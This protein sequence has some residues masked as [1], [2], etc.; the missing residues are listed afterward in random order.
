MTS[1]PMQSYTWCSYF[2]REA[3]KEAKTL[4][5]NYSREVL[6][7]NKFSVRRSKIAFSDVP[8]GRQRKDLLPQYLSNALSH[9]ILADAT[10]PLGI[11]IYSMSPTNG[12]N[13]DS[14]GAYQLEWFPCYWNLTFEYSSSFMKNSALNKLRSL[15]SHESSPFTHHSIL[16]SVGWKWFHR[17]YLELF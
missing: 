9:Q 7:L 11:F 6:S 16:S 17:F 1:S 12:Q 5:I 2:W 14:K 4:G 3:Y 13:M 8:E 15:P 10:N